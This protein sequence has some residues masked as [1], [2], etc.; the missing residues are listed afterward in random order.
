MGYI[1]HAKS[2]TPFGWATLFTALCLGL[3]VEAL[4]RSESNVQSC[5]AALA[6]V[7]ILVLGLAVALNLGQKQ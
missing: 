4:L 6:S 3:L 1:H 7:S 5:I 2:F